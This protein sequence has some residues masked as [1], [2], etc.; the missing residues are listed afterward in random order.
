[1]VKENEVPYLKSLLHY[2]CQMHHQILIL[3]VP[4]VGATF[5]HSPTLSKP[6]TPLH[7]LPPSQAMSPVVRINN[8]QLVIVNQTNAHNRSQQVQIPLFFNVFNYQFQMLNNIP[9]QLLLTLT[10]FNIRAPCLWSFNT[11]SSSKRVTRASRLEIS[12]PYSTI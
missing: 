9:Q 7:C 1:L 11:S 5:H 2:Q 8:A 3:H 6:Q 4:H 10:S 12:L